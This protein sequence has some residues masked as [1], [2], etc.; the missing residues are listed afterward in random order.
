MMQQ[1]YVDGTL[2]TVTHNLPAPLTL[3]QMAE[4]KRRLPEGVRSQSGWT[5]N[6]MHWGVGAIRSVTKETGWV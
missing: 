6:H 3:E 2:V 5:K 4:A 1:A